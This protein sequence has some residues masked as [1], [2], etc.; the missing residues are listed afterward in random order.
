VVVGS[1]VPLHP[2]S[3]RTNGFP[4]SGFP[5]L[6]PSRRLPAERQTGLVTFHRRGLSPCEAFDPGRS[7]R[8][9]QHPAFAPLPLQELPRYYAGLRLRSR[10]PPPDRA[11]RL[12]RRIEL[13]PC[14]RSS[15]PLSPL[16]I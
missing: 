10:H 2:S 16:Y 8:P 1:V 14:P 15:A 13:A 5:S 9:D 3:N 11:N 7:C 12:A 4:V 6:V